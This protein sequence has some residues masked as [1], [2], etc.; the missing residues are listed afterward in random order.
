MNSSYRLMENINTNIRSAESLDKERQMGCVHCPHCRALAVKNTK[1][2]P[3][4][5]SVM[6]NYRPF[7]QTEGNGGFAPFDT[8]NKDKD[9]TKTRRDESM[10]GQPRESIY[11]M[12]IDIVTG[13]SVAVPS[14]TLRSTSLNSREMGKKGTDGSEPGKYTF[15]DN[16]G[17]T[18]YKQ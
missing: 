5:M 15:V 9:I 14:S 4:H 7:D 11:N 13:K 8:S 2:M 1:I 3:P 18:L 16:K 6:D 17:N 12:P 10:R